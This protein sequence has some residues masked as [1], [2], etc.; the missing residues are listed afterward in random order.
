MVLQASVVG[1]VMVAAIVHA[2]W[3]AL[4]K[5]AHDKLHM[6]VVSNAVAGAI[7]GV[8]LLFLPPPDSSAWLIL[9]VSGPLQ[10]LYT[11]L[12]FGAYRVGDLSQVYPI[13]RG[14]SPMFVALG[15][16]V[17]AGEA[18]SHQQYAGIVIV[19]AGMAS[20]AFGRRR[21]GKARDWRPLAYCVLCAAMIATYTVM[22]GIG[23]RRSGS[24]FAYACW[25]FVFYGVGAVCCY[26]FL[27][28]WRVPVHVARRTGRA[29]LVGVGVATAYG[30]V[31]YALSL[32]AM[33][34]I[35]ALRE[36]SVFMAAVIGTAFLGEPFGRQRIVA[37]AIVTIGLL[38]L[39]IPFF[40]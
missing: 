6:Y 8:A 20:L 4:A 17:F 32:G 18:L 28:R 33:A 39:N 9:A 37:A 10:V 5:A 1:I 31:I 24:P 25:L 2:T 34:P 7:G 12:L 23:V 14:L 19:C 36:T 22:D 38:I 15:A 30:L 16:L 26:P 11:A 27:S 29:L 35:S 21:P 40:E 13:I 3:N